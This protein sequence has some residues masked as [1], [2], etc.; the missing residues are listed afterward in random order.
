MTTAD[1][2]T[3]G[4]IGCALAHRARLHAHSTSLSN[5]EDTH[6]LYQRHGF[7]ALARPETFME[8]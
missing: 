7:T 2:R 8:R 1:A 5:G 3:S 4:F 6:A